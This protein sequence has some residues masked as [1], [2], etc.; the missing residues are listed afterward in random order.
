MCTL[1]VEGGE[2]LKYKKNQSS[3]III[4]A[5]KSICRQLSSGHIYYYL[6]I[7]EHSSKHT[8]IT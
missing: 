2:T 3:W 4:G 7:N 8:L 5:V 1:D 6:C